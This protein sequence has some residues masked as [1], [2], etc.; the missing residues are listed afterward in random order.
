MLRPA[1]IDQ[2]PIDQEVNEPVTPEERREFVRANN[3]AVFGYRRKEDGPAMTF[4]YYV[5]EDDDIFVCTMRARAKAKAVLRDPKVSLCVLDGKW[6]PTYLNVYCDAKLEDDFD[7]T[8]DI[9]MRV[10]GVMAG[11]P[12]SDEVR[13]KMERGARAED[14]VLLRLKPYETFATPP[15]HIFSEKDVDKHLTHWTSTT[16]P[17]GD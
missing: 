15:R 3:Q 12:V 7:H 16:M 13:P 8:V 6:P 4:L 2:Q 10:A 9:L 17:W 11:R 14:R 1:R 5:M